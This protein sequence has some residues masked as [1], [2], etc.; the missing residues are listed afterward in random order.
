[1]K[2]RARMR[3]AKRGE[4]TPKGYTVKYIYSD[5]YYR[6]SKDK[7]FVKKKVKKK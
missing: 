7:Y 1:M 2:Q 5:S 3:R 4:K 6:M